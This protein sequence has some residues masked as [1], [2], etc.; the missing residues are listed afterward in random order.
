MPNEPEHAEHEPAQAQPADPGL[1][2]AQPADPE[3]AGAQPADSEPAGAGPAAPR[4]AGAEPAGT[5]PEPA[6]ASGTGW[7]DE[8]APPRQPAP[9]TAQDSTAQDRTAQGDSAAWER[10]TRDSAT[11]DSETQDSAARDRAARDRAAW[12]RKARDDHARTH[13]ARSSPARGAGGA[14]GPGGDLLTDLQRWLLRS[15]A[16]NLRREL[17]GQVRKTLGGP[18][19]DP[20]DVWATATTE[21]PPG[22]EAPEC[23]WCPICRAA[24]RMRETGPGLGSQLAGAGDAVALAVS[25]ALEALDA[26][27]SRAGTAASARKPHDEPDDRG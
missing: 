15:S 23:A 14:G 7:P 1:A 16:K 19:Q 6:E 20:G 12:D 8:T 4:P 24:R 22:D 9:G 18:P 17:S 27:L 26:A 25:D 13:S 2:G 3:P 11:R 21:P 5:P 10:A